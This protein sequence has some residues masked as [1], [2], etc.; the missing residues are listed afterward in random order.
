MGT[1]ADRWGWAT[2]L[3]DIGGEVAIVGVGDADHSNASGRTPQQIAGQA[4]QRAIAHAALEPADVDGILYS[5]GLGD[6]FDAKAFHAH[7]GTRHEMFASA[8][9]GG[10]VWAATAPC[11]AAEALRSGKARHIVNVFSVSWATQRSSMLGGP[12]HFH[13]QERFK[14]NFEVP[15]GWFPQPVYFATIARRHMHEFGTTPQQP[16]SIA[17]ACRRHAN[18][19]AGAVPPAMFREGIGVV[20]EGRLSRNGVFE[21]KRLMVKH[22]NQYQPPS[23]GDERSLEELAKTMQLGADDT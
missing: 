2:E 15:H 1:D 21:T 12:G 7:F 9:G 19:H 13:A 17:V 5:G 22:D 23:E 6:P 18:L 20:V 8:R 11:A 14:R 4:V 10:M 3:D 16:G